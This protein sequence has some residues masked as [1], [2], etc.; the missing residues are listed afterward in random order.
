MG[1]QLEKARTIQ[2]Y[3]HFK[4]E[5]IPCVLEDFTCNTRGS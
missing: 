4:A 3:D 2:K 1:C 5:M